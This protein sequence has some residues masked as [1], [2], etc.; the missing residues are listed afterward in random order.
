[1][2]IQKKKMKYFNR[3]IIPDKKPGKHWLF[4]YL[5]QF[6]DLTRD[7]STERSN[8]RIKLKDYFLETRARMVYKI[9]RCQTEGFKTNVMRSQPEIH[10]YLGPP[11]AA[12]SQSE[13]AFRLPSAYQHASGLRHDV[14]PRLEVQWRYWTITAVAF[15]GP[16][17]DDAADAEGGS[18][19]YERTRQRPGALSCC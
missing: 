5:T 14:R 12:V 10:I 17:P 6:A 9:S 3:Y 2:Q 7:Y 18:R 8:Q 16:R 15:R 4:R 11:T 19:R 1:M 13:A